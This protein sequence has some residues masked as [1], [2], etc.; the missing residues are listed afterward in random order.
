VL[1]AILGTTSSPYLFF[2]QDVEEDRTIGRNLADRITG[3]AGVHACPGHTGVST[4]G[5]Q[6]DDVLI[7]HT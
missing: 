6:V 7:G 4:S 3:G 2:W 5:Y 1:V